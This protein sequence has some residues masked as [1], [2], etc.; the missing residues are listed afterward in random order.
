MIADNAH[1]DFWILSLS[2]LTAAITLQALMTIG[3]QGVLY[4]DT[5]QQR[6]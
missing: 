1:G 6:Q 3:C 2:R 4:E 5:E